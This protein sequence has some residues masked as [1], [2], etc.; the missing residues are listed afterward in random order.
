M[1]F[2]VTA[3][4]ILQLG[5]ELISSDAIAFYELVKN[6]FDARS[7]KVTIRVV[8]RL[9]R[10]TIEDYLK[11][12]NDVDFKVDKKIL[13]EFKADILSKIDAEA[14]NADEA[15][16][17]LTEINDRK[18]LIHF[19]RNVNYIEVEDFGEGMSLTDLEDIY[20][21][22]GTR[23]RK[24]QKAQESNSNRPILGEKGLGR[25]SVMRLGDGVIIETTKSG[26]R[27]FNVIEIDWTVFSHDSDALLHTVK[28]APKLGERK[29][30]R[31]FQGTRIRIT[32]LR[33]PWFKK[34]LE[35]IAKDELA[36][37]IDPFGTRNR[38]F[39]KLWFNKEPVVV[40]GFDNSV[41]E[42]A[43]AF[44]KATLEFD[45][46]DNPVF[47]GEVEDRFY[48]R[49]NAFSLSGTHLASVLKLTDLKNELLSL[50]PFEVSLHW[51]NR[52]VLRESGHPDAKYYEDLV[53]MWGG[54]LMLYRDGFRI[55]PYGGPDDDWLNLDKKALARQGYKMNR[56]QIIGKVDV[57]SKRNPKLVD[58]TNREGLRDN[59]EKNLL[60]LLLQHFI[61]DEVTAFT[62][63]VKKQVE[64]S[65]AALSLKQLEKRIEQGQADVK[66]AITALRKKYPNINNEDKILDKI[67]GVLD[68]SREL[69]RR[70][71]ASADVLQDRLKTTITLAGLGLMVDAIAHELNRSTG[72]ALRTIDSMDAMQLPAGAKEQINTLRLQ[73]KTLRTRLKVI[74][75]LGPSGRQ[76]KTTV[77]LIAIV[78]DV[79]KGHQAQFKRHR[80]RCEF[81]HGASEWR[82]NAVPGMIVQVLENLISNSVYWIK[83]EQNLSQLKDATITIKLD[84][85]A[86][87]IKFSDNGP[88]IPRERKDDV[89][90][91]FFTTKPPAEGKGLGLYISKE[92]AKYHGASFHLE[93]NGKNTLNTF[94]LTI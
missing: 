91:A 34:T 86:G 31:D 1:S 26:E 17:E 63:D 94:V 38:D 68:E 74:D 14:R 42:Q 49:K 16:L 70:A 30:D 46:G 54:G 29:E 10:A 81:E 51:F 32:D 66:M 8:I 9:S 39:I 36:K 61:W 89:F 40:P 18:G 23:Y 47:H 93:D 22:I 59:R 15:R 92:I 45:R 84:R 53:K 75:P 6:S 77:D 3:R 69:F 72:H 58:Q 43:Q 48:K 56:A 67:E 13:E 19:L 37:F 90:R 52:K 5:A 65:K 33:S 4:T 88:G 12:L 44:A 85:K 78:E 73:L 82:I 21:T 25:L 24:E 71:K 11:K 55:N 27:N 20:L 60:I 83:Q 2:K 64:S 80:I 76:Q 7:K 41:F 35:D 87:T 79:I 57:T 62:D 50:G 28:L